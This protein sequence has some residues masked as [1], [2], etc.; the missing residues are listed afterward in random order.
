MSAAAKALAALKTE[1]MLSHIHQQ[2][3]LYSLPCC[4]NLKASAQA[5]V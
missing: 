2:V 5:M 1:N 3:K 4:Y